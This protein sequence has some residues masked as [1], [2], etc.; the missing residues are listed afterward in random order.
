MARVTFTTQSPTVIAYEPNDLQKGD[1]VKLES[2]IDARI[3][4]NKKGQIRM[5]YVFGEKVGLFNEMGSIYATDIVAVNVNEQYEKT[6]DGDR[7]FAVTQPKS[8][9]DAAKMR[10]NIGF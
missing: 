9:K 3:E 2:G 5:A 8:Y 4:D 6:P 1:I 7:W 10:K